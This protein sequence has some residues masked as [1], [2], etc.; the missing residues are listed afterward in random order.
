MGYFSMVKEKPVRKRT[1]SKKRTLIPSE[2]NIQDSIM[3]YLHLNGW[4]VVRVNSSVMMNEHTGA[5]MR[6]YLIYGLGMSSGF[7]DLL[8]L[9]GGQYL[10]LEVKREKGTITLTQQ[11]VY[12]FFNGKSV[13]V[14]Y[15]A[16]IDDVEKILN[17]QQPENH[18]RYEK[19]IKRE[20]FD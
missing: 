10:L 12:K 7:P 17:G 20:L 16:S 13:P 4:I 19:P 2:S 6:S 3:K 15:V 5:P 1:T 14:H 11:R 18:F 8:A 9:K